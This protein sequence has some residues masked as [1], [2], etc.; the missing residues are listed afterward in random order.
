LEVGN[1]VGGA[2]QE[3]PERVTAKLMKSMLLSRRL[4]VIV[5]GICDRK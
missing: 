2:L 5:F 1:L 3:P 4:I